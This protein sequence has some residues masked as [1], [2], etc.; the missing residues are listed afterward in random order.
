M[1]LTR[2]SC[3]EGAVKLEEPVWGRI[4]DPDDI[5]LDVATCTV[6]ILVRGRNAW[7]STWVRHW[8]R[9]SHLYTDSR[10][11]RQGAES[12]RGPGS[13]WYVRERPALLLVASRSKIV[14]FDG[15]GENPFGQFWGVTEEPVETPVGAYLEGIFPGVTLKEAVQ[16]FGGDSRF[17]SRHRDSNNVRFGHAL[18]NIELAGLTSAGYRSW[19]SYPQGS[20]YPLGWSADDTDQPELEGLQRQVASWQQLLEKLHGASEARDRGD[21]D[22]LPLLFEQRF[23]G[24]DALPAKSR[25]ALRARIPAAIESA[26]ADVNQAEAELDRAEAELDRAEA[27]EAAAEDALLD[28]EQFADDPTASLM[29]AIRHPD[30]SSASIRRVREQTARAAELVEEAERRYDAAVAAADEARERLDAA[31]AVLEM[32]DEL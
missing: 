21:H 15:F 8:F 23:E 28:A 27:E 17:W 31:L 2:A 25:A 1:S 4:S 20:D 5:L 3:S 26:Q 22:A 6:T 32:L 10:S 13:K 12:L 16:R 14:A 29:A 9:N 30:A 11:A 24:D 7:H 18:G 19:T